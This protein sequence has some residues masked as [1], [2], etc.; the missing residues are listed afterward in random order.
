[1]PPVSEEPRIKAYYEFLEFY[2]ASR[3]YS[4]QFRRPGDYARLLACLGKDPD[5]RWEESERRTFSAY[6]LYFREAYHSLKVSP[7]DILP[8]EALLLWLK[9]HPYKDLGRLSSAELKKT[10]EAL[11]PDVVTSSTESA[12]TR[13]AAASKKWSCSSSP[14]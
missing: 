14:K 12:V 9:V 4:I 10:L 2:N 11:W 1:M 6:F 8:E 3:L 13:G 7:A 5:E